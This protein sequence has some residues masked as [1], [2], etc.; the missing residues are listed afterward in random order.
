MEKGLIARLKLLFVCGVLELSGK[1][2]M[3]FYKLEVNKEL[4]LKV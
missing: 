1:D 3:N 4:T 2:F